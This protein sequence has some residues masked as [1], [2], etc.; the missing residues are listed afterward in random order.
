MLDHPML[1]HIDSG[2]CPSRGFCGFIFCDVSRVSPY[3][4][5]PVSATIEACRAALT[6][7]ERVPV[8]LL[9]SFSNR[10]P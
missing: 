10:A 9:L 5:S 2:S 4:I 8:N 3:R 6:E 1:G 7:I